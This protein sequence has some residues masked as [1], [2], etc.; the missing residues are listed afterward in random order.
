[1]SARRLLAKPGPIP[2]LGN[3]LLHVPRLLRWVKM[4]RFFSDMK[5]HSEY[6]GVIRFL[7]VRWVHTSYKCQPLSEGNRNKY[8]TDHCRARSVA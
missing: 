6:A 1:L 8:S 5:T 2:K 3:V 7:E 4:Y